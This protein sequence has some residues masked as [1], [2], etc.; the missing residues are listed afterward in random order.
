MILFLCG[1]WLLWA[2]CIQTWLVVCDTLCW[3]II[4]ISKSIT[5]IFVLGSSDQI[6]VYALL[7]CCFCVVSFFSH[8]HTSLSFTFWIHAQLSAHTNISTR[9]ASCG[10][11]HLVCIGRFSLPT[12][13]VQNLKSHRMH[14]LIFRMRTRIHRFHETHRTDS[15]WFTE[16]EPCARVCCPTWYKMTHYGESPRGCR[17]QVS[18]STD[19]CFW[20][21]HL[22]TSSGLK[23]RQLSYSSWSQNLS[24]SRSLHPW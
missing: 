11:S 14:S 3:L 7:P 2:M 16:C 10:S 15:M 4:L 5:S 18:L 9:V 22:V 13:L 23:R 20:E 12:G 21:V 6:I 1:V 8:K 24:L 17:R 19:F